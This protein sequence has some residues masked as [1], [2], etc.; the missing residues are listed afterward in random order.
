M[1][2]ISIGAKTVV[3]NLHTEIKY[4]CDM[5]FLSLTSWN[6]L[7]GLKVCCISNYNKYVL[8]DLN[9]NKLFF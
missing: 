4:K 8:T 1:E 3:Y 5:I 9:D 7:F 2:F 6:I